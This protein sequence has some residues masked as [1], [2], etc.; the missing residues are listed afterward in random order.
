MNIVE[1]SVEDTEDGT[2]RDELTELLDKLTIE[3]I[4]EVLARK[5]K[6]ITTKAKVDAS[7]YTYI[8]RNRDCFRISVDLVK[9][10]F[11]DA[12]VAAMLRVK[13]EETEE[14]EEADKK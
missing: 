7:V 6:N 12:A 3:E 10:M 8:K 11:A 5:K 2:E 1:Q 4:E 13:N 14:N 9:L